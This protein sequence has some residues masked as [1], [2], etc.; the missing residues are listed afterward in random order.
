[1]YVSGTDYVKTL[2]DVL[3]GDYVLIAVRDTGSGMTKEVLERAFEPFY[4]TK[5]IGQ[6]TGLGL[7]QVYGFVRQSGGHVWMES[8]PG[9]GTTV[10]IYLPR[11]HLPR[12]H[13]PESSSDQSDSL[14]PM[15]GHETILVVE[16]A[17]DVRNLTRETLRDFGYDVRE[18]ANASDALQALERNPGISLVFTNIGLPGKLNGRQLADQVQRRWPMMKV[19]LTTGYTQTESGVIG[20]PF[21]EVDLARK[22][23][24]WLDH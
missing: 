7:S 22:V 24:E 16:D 18:A 23:R 15:K 5:E 11:L 9:V 20:K 3:A 17:E 12:L 4:T 13:V 1:M 6:G 19:L 10:S 14:L 2:Q 8:T 21:S